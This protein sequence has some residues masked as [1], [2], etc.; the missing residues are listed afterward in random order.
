MVMDS[1]L[2]SSKPFMNPQ[3]ELNIFEVNKIFKRCVN[4]NVECKHLVSFENYQHLSCHKSSKRVE[5]SEPR[6]HTIRGGSLGGVIK[7]LNLGL[8][9]M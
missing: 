6:I 5:E 7:I 9:D 1:M 4:N 8:F 3:R 2:A